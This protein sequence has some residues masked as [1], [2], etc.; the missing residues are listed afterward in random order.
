[1]HTLRIIMP[2]V[3][4]RKDVQSRSLNAVELVAYNRPHKRGWLPAR[5]S[6]HTR[7]NRRWARAAWEK[8]T[9]RATPPGW[10]AISDQHAGQAG[11]ESA[12]VRDSELARETGQMR[13][14]QPRYYR[15]GAQAPFSREMSKPGIVDIGT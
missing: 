7:F 5:N 6:G 14:E 4:A 11:R 13:L 15:A 2:G 10:P 12:H 1:M 9:V 3:D 8:F